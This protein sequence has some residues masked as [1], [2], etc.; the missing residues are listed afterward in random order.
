MTCGGGER[1]TGAAADRFAALAHVS[2]QAQLVHVRFRPLWAN[3]AF[4]D[5]FGFE[6]VADALAA[7]SLLPL[8][9]EAARDDPAAAWAQ[10][11]DGVALFGRRTLRRRTG[12]DFRAEIY[13]RRVQWDGDEAALLCAL[14][15][16]HEERAL[17]ELAEARTEAHAAALRRR[18]MLALMGEEVRPALACA[19]ES[20]ARAPQTAPSGAL[21]ACNRLRAA[22]DEA[23]AAAAGDPEA[24][25]TVRAPFN[26]AV[27]AREAADAAETNGADVEIVHAGSEGARLIGD[28][29]GVRALMRALIE[30]GAR[31]AARVTLEI[32]ASGAGLTLRATAE[33][34]HHAPAPDTLRTA[35][36]LAAALGGILTARRDED[37]VW[38]AVF[39]APLPVAPAR[40][41]PGA[42]AAL[43]ILVADDRA[44][45][46]RLLEAVLGALGHRVT[47][48]ASGAD[49]LAAFE[50]ARFDLVLMDLNMPGMDGLEAARRM[51]RARVAWAGAP[52]AAMTASL[53]DDVRRAVAEAG[54][55]ALLQKPVPVRR[56][57]E[58]NAALTQRS[59]EP[60]EIEEIDQ[61]HHRDEPSNEIDR[62]H[63]CPA[64]LS[65]CA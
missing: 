40:T 35:R 16:D 34:A 25:T 54:M 49:A 42:A 29:A 24:M 43:E 36:P 1:E 39:Y 22:L 23:L 50:A 12:E 46:R 13:A 63:A 26:P 51:R 44:N 32:E 47:A 56:H 62:D 11:R 9:D 52:I 41:L 6:S 38:R 55:D 2:L 20:L 21:D 31:R 18:Q 33:G 48:A 15:V 45:A 14:D 28:P 64:V 59:D 7:E 5:L 53:G 17:G 3:A 30:A 10:V 65:N 57:A 4:A 60:S 19:I 58:A 27:L 37:G 8:F 61:A